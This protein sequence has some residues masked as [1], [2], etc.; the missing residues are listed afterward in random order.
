MRSLYLRMNR[1][2]KDASFYVTPTASTGLPAISRSPAVVRLKST[3]G[4][5][6]AERPALHIGKQNSR[7]TE[8]MEK[9]RGAF[10]NP[11]LTEIKRAVLCECE[12]HKECD[13]ADWLC[14]AASKPTAANRHHLML[15]TPTHRNNMRPTAF[16]SSLSLCRLTFTKPPTPESL[17]DLSRLGKVCTTMPCSL[18]P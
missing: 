9:R 8:T 7:F 4:M 17:C 10:E 6:V 11:V 13:R 5:R 15:F 14:K 2:S 18:I 1:A 3:G 16:A 12:F